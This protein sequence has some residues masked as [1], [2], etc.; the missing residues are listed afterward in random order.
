[1]DFMDELEK[2][3][4]KRFMLEKFM[5]QKRGWRLNIKSTYEEIE[6]EYKEMLENLEGAAYDMYPNGRDYDAENFDD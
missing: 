4:E 6:S 2:E 1:M 5:K 3:E